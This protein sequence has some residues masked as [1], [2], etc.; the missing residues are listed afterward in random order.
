MTTITMV[1]DMTE[2]PLFTPDNAYQLGIQNL[3]DRNGG[4][5]FFKHIFYLLSQNDM[6]YHKILSFINVKKKSVL[7][8]VTFIG[9]KAGKMREVKAQALLSL[10]V[11]SE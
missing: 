4:D 8:D 10:V 5:S 3:V 9:R 11:W 6:I 7:Q 2:A 1:T